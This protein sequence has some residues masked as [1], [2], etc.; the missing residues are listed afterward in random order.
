MQ[1]SVHYV[2]YNAHNAIYY[3]GAL[4]LQLLVDILPTPFMTSSIPFHSLTYSQST[5]VNFNKVF[6]LENSFHLLANLLW[7]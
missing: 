4:P 3:N 7:C 5:L 1:L 6:D 2:Y